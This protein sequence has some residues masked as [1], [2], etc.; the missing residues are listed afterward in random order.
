MCRCVSKNGS[1]KSWCGRLLV[2]E[3]FFVDEF[4]VKMTEEYG[5]A[6]T[7]C[8]KCMKEIEDAN[9]RP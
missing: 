7:A 1:E 5:S 6:L 9:N 8:E 3:W 2:G 4:H